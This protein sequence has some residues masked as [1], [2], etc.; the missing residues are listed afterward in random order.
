MSSEPGKEPRSEAPASSTP[1][2]AASPPAHPPGPLTRW[3]LRLWVSPEATPTDR[4]AACGTL[5]GTVSIVVNTL[6]FALKLVLGLLTSSVA[7][8]ADGAHSLSDSLTSV[9]VIVAA[10]VSRRPPDAEH[11][12]GHGRAEAIATVAI[13][14][15]LAAAGLEFGK[16]SVG[17]ILHPEPVSAPSWV[18]LLV[19]GT[20][21]VKE[22]LTRFALALASE[23]GNKSVEADAWHHRSDVLSTALVA[24]G[25]LGSSWGFPRLDGI[26][27]VGVSV[28]LLKVGYDIIGGAVDSLLG[29]APSQEEIAAVRHRALAVKGVRGVHDVVIHSYGERRFVSLHIETTDALSAAEVHTIAERVE[30]AVAPDGHGSIAVHMDPI[31]TGHPAYARLRGIVTSSVEAEEAVASFHD[32]RVVG[33]EGRFNVVFDLS[34]EAAGATEE[35][36]EAIVGRLRAAIRETY[37]EAGVV[38]EIDPPYTY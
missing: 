33:G 32:L 22:W 13:A 19:V 2:Q 27:G 36:Q 7:L 24:V 11:P 38:I 21:V 10:K 5:E 9:V 37:P 8:I 14:V 35:E 18:M 1:P 28:V 6:L 23:S 29:R 15:L 20:M 16:V 17:R 26:M 25:M 12:F 30:D 4:R 34:L 3:L 31:D